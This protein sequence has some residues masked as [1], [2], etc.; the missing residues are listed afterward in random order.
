MSALIELKKDLYLQCV[1]IVNDQIQ[2]AQEGMKAAQEAANKEGKSSMG[3]KYET[4]RAM[5]HLEKDKQAMQLAEVSK[6][7]KALDMMNPTTEQNIIAFGSVIKTSSANY[8]LAVSIGQ[9]TVGDESYY[10]IS[11]ATP[12]GQLLLGLQKGDFF[13]FNG[14]EVEITATI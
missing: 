3:D 8:F 10:A 4:G 5:M 9:L 14:N 7:K 1:K 13:T 2:R 6:M 12:V 11:P